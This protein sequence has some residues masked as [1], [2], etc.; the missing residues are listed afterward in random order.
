MY[1]LINMLKKQYHE[2][3]QENLKIKTRIKKVRKEKDKVAREVNVMKEIKEDGHLDST[4]NQERRRRMLLETEWKQKIKKKNQEMEKVMTRLKNVKK[5][6]KGENI[7]HLE[8]EL[9]FYSNLNKNLKREIKQR[10]ENLNEYKEQ[11]RQG[12][13]EKRDELQRKENEVSMLKEKLKELME[14]KYE[15]KKEFNQ[16]IL[17][18]EM[19]Q[20]GLIKKKKKEPNANERM[21][22]I[23]LKESIKIQ[24]EEIQNQEEEHKKM[25]NQDKEVDQ[26]Q[27]LHYTKKN[28][29]LLNIDCETEVD[30]DV[31]FYLE[32]G[33]NVELYFEL[34][35]I[36]KESFLKNVAKVMK[37]CVQ[38][39]K[40]KSDVMVKKLGEKRYGRIPKGL[41]KVVANVVEC[42]LPDKLTSKEK[43]NKKIKINNKKRVIAMAE[44]KVIGF[45]KENLQY[46]VF[47]ERGTEDLENVYLNKLKKVK[48]KLRKVEFEKKAD[49]RG[50]EAWLRYLLIVQHDFTMEESSLVIGSAFWN[51]KDSGE[52]RVDDLKRFV[53]KYVAYLEK[54][55]K[56]RQKER[57]DKELE[58]AA[59]KI[60]SVFKGK[61]ARKEVK[62]LKKQ[63]EKKTENV[64]DIG[65]IEDEIEENIEEIEEEIVEEIAEEIDEDIKEEIDE[66]IADC[67]EK[68]DKD[69]VNAAIKIQGKFRQKLAK[70]KVEKLKQKKKEDEEMENAAVLI[71]KNFKRKQAKKI[72][73]EKKKIRKEE[74]QA[75]T[76]IQKRYKEKMAK[77]A[78]EK[79]KNY[80][81]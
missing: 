31:L 68:K 59:L 16:L 73:E 5:E 65:K 52:I 21:E 35:G 17:D 30:E 28:E 36:S 41:A 10:E 42:I 32:G 18:E 27:G 13:K 45:F 1:M 70:K 81:L 66:D 51:T 69:M 61:K 50:E 67:V 22:R 19:K 3:N 29:I 80:L 74:E 24:I 44:R 14:E 62:E 76:L 43:K 6:M 55:A 47:N 60:Q 20:N 23:K 4:E 56:K 57:E 54:K 2:V 12:L 63:K 53:K 7:K 38:K 15:V 78:L 64:E 9:K 72:L 75:A 46:K 37:Y 8:K 49:K 25:F 71:Q 34:E 40:F 26:L 48:E 58:A 79:G 11:I 77:R 39:D 33:R